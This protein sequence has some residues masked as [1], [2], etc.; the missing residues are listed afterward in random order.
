MR[1]RGIVVVAALAAAGCGGQQPDVS[2]VVTDASV[3]APSR[4][5]SAASTVTPTTPAMAPNVAEL[6]S[7]VVREVPADAS[8]AVIE[9]GDR[10]WAVTALATTATIWSW[11]GETWG[12][13]RRLPL[14]LPATDLKGP[15]VTA[16]LTGDR[17]ADALVPMLGNGFFGGVLSNHDGEWRIIHFSWADGGSAAYLENLEVQGRDLVTYENVCDPSCAH[18]AADEVV[19]VY[20]SKTDSFVEQERVEV[21]PAAAPPSEVTPVTAAP[22]ASPTGLKT[23]LDDLGRAFRVDDSSRVVEF[24][25]VWWGL[26]V[27]GGEPILFAWDGSNW[28]MQ[29]ALPV[30]SQHALRVTTV[31]VTEDGVRDFVIEFSSGV[32]GVISTARSGSWEWLLF[33]DIDGGGYLP[34]AGDFYVYDNGDGT[35]GMQTAA[36]VWVWNP[37]WGAFEWFAD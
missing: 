17:R 36:L 4:A 14:V 11:D 30:A 37:E 1:V 31:D 2:A 18:G 13:Y 19:W 23:A 28:V 27:G 10:R 24:A 22:A 16:D 26:L 29:G 32:G 21:S 34:L 9:D 6:W 8:S 7:D 12:R 15:I 33:D 5:T 35:G 20:D 25:G 3:A